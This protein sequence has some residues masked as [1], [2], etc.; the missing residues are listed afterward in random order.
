MHLRR[1]RWDSFIHLPRQTRRQTATGP[2][3]SSEGH[4]GAS[5]GGAAAGSA[6]L[7]PQRV[8]FLCPKEPRNRRPKK[9]LKRCYDALDADE[10]VGPVLLDGKDTT[11]KHAHQA[12]ALWCPEVYFDARMERLRKLETAMKR[13]KQM[14]CAWCKG[15]GAAIGCGIEECPRSYHLTCAHEANCSFAQS[16]FMLACPRH[17]RRLATERADARWQD[18]GVEEAEPQQTQQTTQTTTVGF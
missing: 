3:M 8:C 17:V 4:R 6:A 18:V 5:G 14:P 10:W 2:A 1:D 9:V 12:C 16:E 15:K 13:A 7:P 11:P